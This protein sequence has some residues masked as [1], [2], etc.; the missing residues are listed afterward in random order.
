MYICLVTNSLQV[1]HNYCNCY[2]QPKEFSFEIERR[3]NHYEKTYSNIFNNG[4]NGGYGSARSKRSDQKQ[5]K[6]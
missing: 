3:T 1:W 2:L 4:D 6:L 5:K